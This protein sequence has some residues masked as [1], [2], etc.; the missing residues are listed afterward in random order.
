MPTTC[1]F[2]RD[3]VDAMSPARTLLVV[4]AVVAIPPLPAAC[5]QHTL[6]DVVYG[7]A[8]GHD[9]K[10]DAFLCDSPKLSPVVIYIHGGGWRQGDKRPNEKTFHVE[11]MIL[12]ALKTRMQSAG[13]AVVSIN[14]RLSDVAVF[15]AQVDD[16]TR[17]VKYVRHQAGEWRL[18][19]RKI[20]VLGPSAGGHL[21]LWIGLHPDRANPRSADPV[22]RESTRVR[23]IVNYYG[24]TDF[25]LVQQHPNSYR[26]PAFRQLFGYT[27]SDSLSRLT[28]EQ[29]N[30]ASPVSYIGRESPPVFT[31]HGTGDAVVP[32]EQ[33]EVLIAKLAEKGVAAE[34]YLLPGGNHGL[35]NPRPDWP[36]Y[37]RAAFEFLE[38]YLLR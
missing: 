25:H 2:S 29:I 5:E 14:Y 35:S 34:S 11:R 13:I 3:K 26:I 36:D 15:P 24:L 22:E 28:D 33:A 32:V 6:P 19:S 18:D 17:A 27:E 8:G 30:A 12:D 9:L 20:A 10:L 4:L 21:A 31:A 37:Q 23:C 1:H 16:V 38:K 7:R